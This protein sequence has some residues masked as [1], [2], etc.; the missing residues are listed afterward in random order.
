[1]SDMQNN[2]DKSLDL[3]FAAAKTADPIPSRDLMARVL[4]DAASV[5]ASHALASEPPVS[6]RGFALDLRDIFGGWAGVSGLTACV[7]LGVILGLY[8]PDDVLNYVPGFENAV[9]DEV[10]ALYYDTEY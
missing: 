1:M 3:L 5:Q 6:R 4:T 9:S 10:F 2:E 7:C 8:S